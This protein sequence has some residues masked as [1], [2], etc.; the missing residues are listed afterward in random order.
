[1]DRVLSRF[2]RATFRKIRPKQILLRQREAEEGLQM[3]GYQ[4]SRFELQR[5]LR[6]QSR[7]Y[8]NVEEDLAGVED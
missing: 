4:R 7:R 3:L 8:Q 1:M 6:S 2:I 5:R